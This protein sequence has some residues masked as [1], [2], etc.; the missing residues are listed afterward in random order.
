MLRRNAGRKQEKQSTEVDIW[1][2]SRRRDIAVLEYLAADFDQY[3]TTRTQIWD[4]A[5]LSLRQ[6]LPVTKECGLR[7]R[8]TGFPD[9]FG[10]KDFDKI[11]RD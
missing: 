2:N 9:R 3:A 1:V 6:C 8:A 11:Y 10:P 5:G 7:F 4:L